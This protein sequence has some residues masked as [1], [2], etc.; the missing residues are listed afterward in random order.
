VFVVRSIV[1]LCTLIIVSLC[2][3]S[4]NSDVRLVVTGN[5]MGAIRECHCP[6][7]QPGGLARRKTIF[8]DIRNETPEAIFI[9]CGRLTNDKMDE[10]EIEI[11]KVLLDVLDYDLINCYLID[12]YKAVSVCLSHR[13]I[14][15]MPGTNKN[16]KRSPSNYTSLQKCNLN[17]PFESDLLHGKQST[18]NEESLDKWELKRKRLFEFSYSGRDS[19]VIATRTANYEYVNVDTVIRKRFS[20]DKPYDLSVSN[21]KNEVTPSDFPSNALSVLVRNMV[22]G[23]DPS[24]DECEIPM[25]L[26]GTKYLPNLDVVILGND[27]HT[28]P[29]VEKSPL[30]NY[31]SQ[32]SEIPK[33]DI[34]IVR[35]GLYGEY[36][37]VLDL[38]ITD[39]FEIASFEWE[40]IPSKSVV[41]DSSMQMF[42]SNSYPSPWIEE[43]DR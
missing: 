26:H 41:P 20:L 42:I 21:G 11:L 3:A 7:G 17:L 2:C 39:D 27:G 8:D 19:V 9:E 32:E 1:F 36:V 37:I 34:L 23:D 12:Y 31:Y 10:E 35:P 13:D 24:Q 38:E 25:E 22:F 29:D 14:Y 4:E 6:T 43:L 28:E 33:K 18:W 15:Y 30:Q 40:A 5:L 16:R